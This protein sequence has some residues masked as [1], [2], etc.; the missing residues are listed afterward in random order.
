MK[1]Y[2][3]VIGLFSFLLLCLSG[4]VSSGGFGTYYKG[5]TYSPSKNVKLYSYSLSSL[6]ELKRQ[7][8]EIIGE[9]SFNGPDVSWDDAVNQAKKIGADI[10]LA[11]KRQTGSNQVFYPRTTYTPGKTYTVN[12]YSSGTASAYGTG[13]SAYGGYS[14]TSTSYVN[15][16]GYTTKTY[17]PHT[18]NRFDFQAIFLRMGWQAKVGYSE[19]PTTVEDEEKNTVYLVP[20]KMRIKDSY[21][22]VDV[23]SRPNFVSKKIEKVTRG[24][25]FEVVE[26]IDVWMKIKISKAGGFGYV[27]DSRVTE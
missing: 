2:L 11:E 22:A 14:G 25:Y 10:V 6:E 19:S 21:D 1:K 16:P 23:Y 7:G 27:L 3:I 20:K 5:E 9:A 4:C 15:T 13:G 12:S 18:I 8:Y 26:K 24:V 17:I